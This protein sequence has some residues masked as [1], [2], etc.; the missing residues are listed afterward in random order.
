VRSV[1]VAVVA[2]VRVEG[3]NMRSGLHAHWK[4]DRRGSRGQRGGGRKERTRVARTSVVL[5]MLTPRLADSLVSNACRKAQGRGTNKETWQRSANPIWSWRRLGHGI[6][7][8][9]NP[10]P[11][12]TPYT[13]HRIRR[14][15]RGW[16]CVAEEKRL[17]HARCLPVRWL[18]IICTRAA[19]PT[20]CSA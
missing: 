17:L 19:P 4:R 12:P 10:P 16:S 1:R 13:V 9:P 15:W 7:T 20:S 3:T 14:T 6:A 18:L 8:F 5:V 2:Y 11:H